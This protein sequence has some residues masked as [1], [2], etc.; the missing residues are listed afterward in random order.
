MTHSLFRT[1]RLVPCVGLLLTA[2]ALA[3]VPGCS[4]APPAPTTYPVTGT[5]VSK[6]Q[7][8]A[9]TVHGAINK[10][11]GTFTLFTMAGGRGD[12]QSGAPEGQYE[13]II[14]PEQGPQEAGA[15]I[16]TPFTVPGPFT[17]KAQNSND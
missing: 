14:V 16:A 1:H 9:P 12:K 10:Q 4:S 6:D 11:D 5:A 15:P 2:L 13:A 17:V 7:K 3:A 8:H